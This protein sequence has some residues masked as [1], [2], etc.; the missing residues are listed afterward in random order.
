MHID[1]RETRA[2]IRA[3][4]EWEE[5]AAAPVAGSEAQQIVSLPGFSELTDPG[6]QHSRCE[7]FRSSFAFMNRPP[8][9]DSAII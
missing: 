4:Y 9:H 3:T 7:S 5:D 1:C 2:G 8:P 6:I